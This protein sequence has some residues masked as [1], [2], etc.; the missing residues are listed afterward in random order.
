MIKTK[1][2]L[3]VI[4][5]RGGST[6]IP[7]KNI[8]ELGEH[9]LIAYT[10]AAAL[11]S[12]YIDNVVVSTDCKIIAEIAMS[13]GAEVPFLRIPEL[14]GDRVSSA[15]SLKWFVERF[16]DETKHCYDVIIELPPV[17]PFR[18]SWHVDQSLEKLVNTNA[19][20]VISVVNTGEKHPT[21]LKRIDGD[22]ISD[23][24]KEFP[25][26]KISRRQDL[27][28]CFIR[29]G[30]IYAMKHTTLFNTLSRR[31]A[32]SR[33]LEMESQYSINIDCEFDLLVARALVKY[34]V[35]ENRPC[36]IDSRV[37]KNF[38]NGATNESVG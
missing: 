3:A 36:T 1:S 26:P 7:K 11:K 18:T 31:G 20:S 23:F 33:P 8:V 6:G 14:A 32:I 5:A 37:K 22:L 19:D 17:A 10:I 21:R 34:G 4:Q 24:T 12:Q 27:D 29:N 30:A 28:P 9:P 16:E 35:C 38:D 2:V 15:E 25:E 13:Y